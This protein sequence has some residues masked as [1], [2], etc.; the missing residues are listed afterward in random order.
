[1]LKMNEKCYLRYF[2]E[3]R[4]LVLLSSERK[5]ENI[6]EECR[7]LIIK[8]VLMIFHIIKKLQEKYNS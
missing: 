1:M 8:R 5:S 2:T 7:Q 6:L 3:Q 4:M